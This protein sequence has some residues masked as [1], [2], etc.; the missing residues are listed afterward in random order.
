MAKIEQFSRLINHGITTAG[1]TFTIPT[2]NDHT[3][4][5]WLATDL[6]LGELGVNLTDDKVYVRTNNGIIQLA[7]G[8]SSTGS[9]ASTSAIFVFNSPNIQ[10]GSTYSADALTPRS[11]YYTDLGTTTLRWKD[12]Y[13]GGSSTGLATINANNGLLITE[14]SDAI[15]VTNGIVSNN[16]PIEIDF[17]ASLTT[18]DRQTHI[19]SRNVQFTGGSIECVSLASVSA[20]ASNAS[21]TVLIGAQNVTVANSLNSVV[22]LGQ[23]YSKTNLYTETVYAGAKFAVRGA[24]DDGSGQY[25]DSDWMTAQSI[26]RTTDATQTPLVSVAWNDAVGGGEVVTVKAY[27]TGVTIDDATEVYSSEF[28]AAFSI[29]ASLNATIIGVPVKNEVSSYVGTQPIVEGYADGTGIEISVKGLGSTTIQWLCSY[30]Y[31]RL[32]NVV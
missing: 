5:T 30:S 13:L 2:S 14:A 19:N 32:I 15:L 16:A 20:S 24:S 1:T 9:T 7:T 28:F 6:Y 21:S 29:D 31:H 18:K 27:I 3:D 25:A 26:L 11:G 10:I 8:T 22:H 17:K 12:L 4:E 23:G